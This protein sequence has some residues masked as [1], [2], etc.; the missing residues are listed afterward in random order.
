MV[1]KETYIIINEKQIT[2]F[3]ATDRAS[4]TGSSRDFGRLVK[5][6]VT[7]NAVKHWPRIG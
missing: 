2:I 3:K 5:N 4:D 1:F 7:K 6:K